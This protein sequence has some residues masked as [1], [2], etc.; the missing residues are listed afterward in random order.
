MT[1]TPYNKRKRK[2][3][4]KGKKKR[5]LLLKI[6]LGILIVLL[7]LTAGVAGAYYYLRASGKAGLRENAKTA[8]PDLNKSETIA[9]S[10]ELQEEYDPT[11]FRYGGK[12]YKYNSNIITI[13]CMG[14][15]K[16][17]EGVELSD[18]SGES[19]QADSIFLLVIDPSVNKVKIIAVS[20]DT[21]TDITNYDVTGKAIGESVNH[22]GLAYAYGDGGETSCEMMVDA[23]SNLFYDLPIHGY[24]SLLVSAIGPL[25]D[26]V[27]GVTVTVPQDL[28]HKDPALTEGATVTLMGEQAEIFVRNRDTNE[29]GS[30]NQ[31]MERQKTYALAFV[32][33]AKEA[34]KA[35]PSLTID[36]YQKFSKQMVT[37]IGLDNAVYLVSEVAGMEFDLNDIY[38]LKGETKQ[39]AVYEEFY[40]DDKAL[41]QLVL[42]TFYTEVPEV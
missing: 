20:R 22:L 25:N 12:E 29:E 39:G 6:C 17:T 7:A 26:A 35:N 28:S 5:F 9:K 10:Q 4:L 42:D 30:N 13:L 34:L 8:V 15:D 41:L 2:R 33:Q 27:G 3:I 31:R 19:G 38:T 16:D 24:V 37:N 18:I 21:M 40:A 14:I 1:Y 11:V 23:V 36:L 32:N